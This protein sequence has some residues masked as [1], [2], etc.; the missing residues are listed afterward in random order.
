MAG[1]PKKQDPVD[2]K[3]LGAELGLSVGRINSLYAEREKNDFPEHVHQRGRARLW[4]LA[5]VRDWYEA[6]EPSRLQ[7]LSLA[8]GDPDELLNAA[9]VAK[10]LGYKN[11][12]QIT[13]YLIEHPGY[14]PAPDEVEE[15]GTYK[16]QK[17]RRRTIA[18]WRA[19]RPGKGKRAGATRQA[20]ALP[21]VPAH[22]DPDELLAGTQAAALLGFKSLNSFS[23]SLSQ[24]NLPLLEEADGL[25]DRGKRAWTRRRILEQKAQRG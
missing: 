3:E 15:L 21:D 4:D 2:S 5:E 13:T 9:Q 12:S 23:S 19:T 20:P 25:S 1:K 17:W 6:R 18:D 8:S 14:F 24:G 16:R 11:R 7:Q 10:L 22:G